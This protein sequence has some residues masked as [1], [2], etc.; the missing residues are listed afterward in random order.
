MDFIFKICFWNPLARLDSVLIT[1][2]NIILQ[3]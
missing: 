1:S 2:G 3:V